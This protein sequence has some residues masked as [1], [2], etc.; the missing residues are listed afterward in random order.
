MYT[1]HREKLLTVAYISGSLFRETCGLFNLFML[2]CEGIW[3][4]WATI[5]CC[6]DPPA[7]QE[8]EG[9]KEGELPQVR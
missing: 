5:C 9:R 2:F 4:G 3:P 1:G 8:L 7:Q 6:E